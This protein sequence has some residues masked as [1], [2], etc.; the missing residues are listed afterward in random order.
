MDRKFVTARLRVDSKEMDEVRTLFSVVPALE[1]ANGGPDDDE[2][3]EAMEQAIDI[4]IENAF[5]DPHFTAR[6]QYDVKSR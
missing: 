1:P 3:V 5:P 4:S 6:R 2:F